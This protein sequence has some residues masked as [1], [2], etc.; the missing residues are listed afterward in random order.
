MKITVSREEA[1]K[2]ISEKILAGLGQAGFD[3]SYEIRI[4]ENSPES[5]KGGASIVGGIPV[6]PTSGLADL[7]VYCYARQHALSDIQFISIMNENTNLSI[8][9]IKKIYNATPI[10]AVYWFSVCG[11]SKDFEFKEFYKMTQSPK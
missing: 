5:V 10:E 4:E 3:S 8:E 6:S 2:A 9:T 11:W 1:L 7:R